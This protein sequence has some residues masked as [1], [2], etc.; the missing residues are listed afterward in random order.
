MVA[1]L[2]HMSSRDL[3]PGTLIT[4][5]G[6]IHLSKT[7]EEWLEKYRSPTS[8]RRPHSV[9]AAPWHDFTRVGVKDGFIYLVEMS[10]NATVRD[11]AWISQLQ[12]WELMEKH[13]GQEIL[14]KFRNLPQTPFSEEILKYYVQSYWNGTPSTNP[15]WEV[16][17]QQLTVIEKL[18]PDPVR[19]SDTLGGLQSLRERFPPP[20]P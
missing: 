15:A 10:A 20:R 1:Y 3:L 19:R 6:D 7:I 8:L 17:D 13:S 2:F 5:R 18:T 12:T 14:S 11:T 9:F 16:V 4:P